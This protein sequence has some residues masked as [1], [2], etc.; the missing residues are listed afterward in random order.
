MKGSLG[1]VL[2]F[3]EGLGAAAEAPGT[4]SS[5]AAAAATADRALRVLRMAMLGNGGGI[6]GARE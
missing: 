4:Q 6:S 5:A 3:T 1:D 2:G